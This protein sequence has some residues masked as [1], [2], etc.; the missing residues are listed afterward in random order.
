MRGEAVDALARQQAELQSSLGHWS[1]L[2]SGLSALVQA[3]ESIF[4]GQGAEATVEP[5]R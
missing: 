5:K 3:C 1:E 4:E 2:R